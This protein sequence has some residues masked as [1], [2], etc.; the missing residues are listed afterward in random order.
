MYLMESEREAERLE[1]KTD[2]EEVRR[3]LDLVGILPGMQVLDAGAGSG[4]VSRVIS[5]MVGP[6]GRV[7]ALEKSP[8][9]A[10][11]AA[12]RGFEDRLANLDVVQAD[13]YHVP[14][15]QD[16]FDLVWCEFVF[17]YLRDQVAAASVLANAVRPGGRLIVA[18]LDG[19]AQFHYPMPTEVKHGLE[20]VMRVLES[21]FDPFVGR[22]LYHLLRKAG[23]GDI[24]VHMLP[25][26]FYPGAAPEKHI[27]HWRW[28]FQT[29]SRVVAP[30]F[31][32][33]ESYARWVESFLEMLHDPDRF[34][35]SVLFIV[36][37]R[38]P[39]GRDAERLPSAKGRFGQ[40]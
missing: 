40:T 22:K 16:S 39:T 6:L 7:V 33:E 3:R 1:F 34:S 8:E 37:G 19:Y 29:I 26:H 35:Y 25:Y 30:T 23:L 17:E 38:K 21:Q 12:R 13:L 31:G 5:T 10:S 4:A 20:Q 11:F 24:K 28:K 27:E 14:F 2:A 15:G 32:G 9:R 18:D 36:E